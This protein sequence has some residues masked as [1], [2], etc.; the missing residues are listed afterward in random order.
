MSRELENVS[1]ICEADG[2]NQKVCPGAKLM[3]TWFPGMAGVPPAEITRPPPSST[4]WGLRDPE[5]FSIYSSLLKVV[6]KFHHDT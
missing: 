1:E 5:S 2:Q 4:L 6:S 3:V